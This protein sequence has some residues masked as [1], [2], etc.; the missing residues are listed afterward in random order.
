ML[1]IYIARHGQ[2]V[3]NANGI[4]NGHRDLP[5]TG[6]GR[7]QAHSAGEH[8]KELGL[9]FEATYSSPLSR[10]FETAQIIAEVS[11]NPAPVINKDLIE[12]DFGDMAG[13]PVESIPEK[14]KGEMLPTDKVNYMLEPSNGET[15]PEAL[16]RAEHMLEEI[17]AN[18]QDG[19]VLLVCHMD[20]SYMLVASYY[21]LDWKDVLRKLFFG[22]SELLLLAPDHAL[23]TALIHTTKQY[24]I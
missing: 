9:H 22:N 15:F 20:I 23:E 1:K 10:A 3:D 4:L 12:R 11:L 16:I 2:N 14:Y 8:I 24:N 17:R 7:Q 13:E 5:L 19:N 18:H 6:L 21:Q